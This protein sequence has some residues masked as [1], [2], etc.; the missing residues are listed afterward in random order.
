[1][2]SLEFIEHV[3]VF[4]TVYMFAVVAF[5]HFIQYPMLKSVPEEARALYNK[6]YCDRAGFVIAPAMIFEAFTALLLAFIYSNSIYYLGLF[7]ILILWV[8]TFFFSV[9]AHTKLCNAWDSKAHEKLMSSNFI[10]LIAW[11]IRCL[12]LVY[13]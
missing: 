7:F 2:L 5:V 13:L 4:C 6:K 1:M 9:P 3:H 12:I 10:R 11:A 8:V